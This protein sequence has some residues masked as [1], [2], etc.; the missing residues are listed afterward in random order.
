MIQKKEVIRHKWFGE[1][2]FLSFLKI[3]LISVSVLHYLRIINSVVAIIIIIFWCVLCFFLTLPCFPFSFF[4]FCFSFSLILTWWI[5]Y[6]RPERW[7]CSMNVYFNEYLFSTQHNWELRVEDAKGG[8]LSYAFI[9][10]DIGGEYK[11]S[12]CEYLMEIDS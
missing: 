1:N 2:L 6:M 4:L 12:I 3:V 10:V 9:K 8:K 5:K 7:R 11:W